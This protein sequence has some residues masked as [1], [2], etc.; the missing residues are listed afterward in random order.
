MNGSPYPTRTSPRVPLS[1]LVTLLFLTGASAPLLAQSS[2]V[3]DGGGISLMMY[4][5]SGAVTA[6]WTCDDTESSALDTD[7]NGTVANVE[8][9]AS[10]P[11]NWPNFDG[12]CG[13]GSVNSS[14]VLQ[15]LTGSKPGRMNGFVYHLVQSGNFTPS[16]GGI[17]DTGPGQIG[18][19][20]FM[21]F[22]CPETDPHCEFTDP[23]LVN[24]TL[25]PDHPPCA[26]PLSDPTC[27]RYNWQ[28]KATNEFPPAFH[29][30]E[31]WAKLQNSGVKY[32]HD[33][34]LQ[35]GQKPNTAELFFKDAVVVMNRPNTPVPFASAVQRRWDGPFSPRPPAKGWENAL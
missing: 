27:D 31:V 11:A 32:F 6:N 7:G 20:N 4:H 14:L 26:D 19:D 21:L 1:L 2:Y 10:G 17:P 33:N 34:L 8:C 15:S 16:F 3:G 25:R 5:T 13:S 12:P 18:G 35:T 23:L 22:R 9:Y 30:L 29:K 28:L 24:A